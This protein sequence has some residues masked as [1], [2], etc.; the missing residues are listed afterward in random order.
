MNYVAEW[1]RYFALTL[2]VELLVAVPLLGKSYPLARRAAA[3]LFAQL[4]SHPVVWFVIP[5]FGLGRTAF[6]LVAETWAVAIE[7]A[8]YRLVF[9]ELAWTRAAAVSAIANGASVVVGTL[10]R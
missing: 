6:L 4:V 7:L 8:L 1:A 9:P 10:V 2:T 3:V 5:A